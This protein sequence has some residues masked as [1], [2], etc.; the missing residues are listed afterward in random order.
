M[1]TLPIKLDQRDL[2]YP[3]LPR[4]IG[5]EEVDF[6][7]S[8][9]NRVNNIDIV[10]R[11]GYFLNILATYDLDF[12]GEWHHEIRWNKR[13]NTYSEY[14]FQDFSSTS[15]TLLMFFTGFLSLTIP[16]IRRRYRDTREYY[17]KL[18]KYW[19]ANYETQEEKDEY[20][21]IL[22]EFR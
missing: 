21:K 15:N 2:Y 7:N 13:D 4:D 17:H 6:L 3:T 9:E 20:M 5:I 12:L 22:G 10:N 1:L 14:S 16:K 8:L 19:L 18:H 11:E